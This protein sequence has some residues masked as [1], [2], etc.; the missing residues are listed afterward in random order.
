MTDWYDILKKNEIDIPE[1]LAYQKES[2]CAGDS[3][4]RASADEAIDALVT[5]LARMNSWLDAQ[6]HIE[7][8]LAFAVLM[9]AKKLKN[10]AKKMGAGE[11]LLQDESWLD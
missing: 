6:E 3:L 8:G 4:I 10:I 7:Q 5:E 11:Q 9:E 2:E 1:V